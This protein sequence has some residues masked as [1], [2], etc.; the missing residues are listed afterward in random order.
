MVAGGDHL[1]DYFVHADEAL[2]V[3]GL[4]VEGLV[5]GG[6]QELAEEG[7][8]QSEH[9]AAAESAEADE[10]EEEEEGEEAKC[11]E[12]GADHIDIIPKSQLF[13]KY[14]KRFPREQ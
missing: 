7:G 9:A 5:V 11:E 6:G 8:D 4:A 2:C 14:N 12:N 10:E 13:K 1:V 3:D